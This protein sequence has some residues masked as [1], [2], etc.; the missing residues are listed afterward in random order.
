MKMRRISTTLLAL[1]L[2]AMMLPTN[3]SAT[4][5]VTGNFVFDLQAT[6][7]DYGEAINNVCF[8]INP[9]EVSG[10]QVDL[11][12]IDSDTFEVRATATNPHGEIPV[13]APQYGVYTDVKRTIEEISVSND[14]KTISLDLKTT[15]EGPGQGTLNYVG[16]D[17][18]RNLSMDISYTVKQ[19]KDFSLNNGTIVK[20]DSNYTMGDIHSPEVEKFEANTY[21]GPQSTISYQSFTPTNYKNGE[22]HPL[23][24]WFHGNGEGGYGDIKNNNSQL[25]AN[26]GAVAFSSDEAQEIFGGAYVLAPQAPDTWYYDHTN[27][28]IDTM[29]ALINE[30]VEV[31]NIDSNRIYVY[32]CSAGGYMTTRMAI[33]NPTLFAAVVPTCAAVNVALSRGG[34]ETTEAEIKTLHSNNLW[35]VH[36]SNDPT[37][38]P[39]TSSQWMH[40]LLPNSIYTEYPSVI[41]GG[42]S[43]P[44][45]WSWIYTALNMPTTSGGEKIWQW[46]AKQ[47]LETK[48]VQ[49]IPEEVIPKEKN[50]VKTNDGRN[51]STYGG[52]SVVA[53]AVILAFSYKRKTA[54]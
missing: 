12:T 8:S 46:T 11:T 33:A 35:F 7:F 15:Y 26:R 53:M 51:T 6:V 14:G 34:V 37:V 22:K 49:P 10:A 43:Y 31:N 45:H 39:E 38:V 41:I 19:V 20:S 24:I 18:A 52:V 5:E 16:G 28:Y 54:G 44:G 13:E 4:S 2:V 47:T 3:V 48:E 36:A 23:V 27:G 32:G 40:S 17:V 1:I 25:R 42:V 30:Y 9:I 29:S 50:I 21:V